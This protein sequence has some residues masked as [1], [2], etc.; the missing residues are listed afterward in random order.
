MKIVKKIILIA[1][2]PLGANAQ[3]TVL[4]DES[5][6]R[7]KFEVSMSLL[8]EFISTQAPPKYILDSVTV[9]F[10][11]TT[12]ADGSVSGKIP[13]GIAGVSFEGA[14]SA[15][16]TISRSYT[17]TPAATIPTTFDDLGVLEFFNELQADAAHTMGG[18]GLSSAEYSET[19]YAALNGEGKLEFFGVAAIGGSINTTNSHRM[20]F[21]FCLQGVDGSCVR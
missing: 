5:A 9:D 15:L 12:G 4:L 10:S 17:Y 2:L 16:D 20:T 11:V 18:M 1:L 13:V 19:F 14:Y 8:N 6:V 21:R 7:E 3:E